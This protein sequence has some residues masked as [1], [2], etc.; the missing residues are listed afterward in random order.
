MLFSSYGGVLTKKIQIHHENNGGMSRYEKIP[1]YLNWSGCENPEDQINEYLDKFSIVAKKNVIKSNWVPGVLRYLRSNY[2]TKN[3]YLISATPQLEIEQILIELGILNY[4]DKIIGTS[5]KND[6]VKSIL[7]EF[8]LTLESSVFIGDSEI[9]Y[10]AAKSNNISFVL[11]STPFNSS[12]QKKGDFLV[13]ND[14][15]NE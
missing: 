6:A 10:E 9:D 11:R 7:S 12:L 14:F 1:L 8:S 3:F 5:K 15:I 13:I 2:I 4:F